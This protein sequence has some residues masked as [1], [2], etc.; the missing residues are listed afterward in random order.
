MAGL[1]VHESQAQQKEVVS[2]SPLTTSSM[3]DDDNSTSTSNS[4]SSTPLAPPAYDPSRVATPEQL[5]VLNLLV[6]PFWIF[7]FVERRMRWANQA[8]LEL[9]NASSL[10]ELQ[11]RDFQDISAASAKRMEEMLLKFEQGQNITEQWTMYP[12]GQAKTVHMNVSGIRLSK[13]DDHMSIM[14]EGIPL[15]KEELLNETLRGV[16]MLRHLPMAVC[17]FDME[18]KVI[19]QNPEGSLF[20]T[21]EE[22][23]DNHNNSE[24][25]KTASAA[26]ND[27]A[28]QMQES[29]HHNHEDIDDSKSTNNNCSN[30]RTAILHNKKRAGNLVNRFVDTDVG[31]HVLKEIQTKELLDIEAMLHTQKGQRWSAIQVRRGKDPVTGE[32]VILYSA[33]D[34][35]DAIKAKKEREARKQKSEFLAIMAHEIRT[36]LHQVTGFIDLLD[37]TNLDAEQRS[38]VKLLK[39]SAQ[40]LMTVISDVLDY[41]KLEAGRMKLE[42]IPYEPLSVVGGSIEAVRASC[43]EKNLYLKV[44]WNKEIP[45]RLL[46]DPNRLRQVL[47]NLLSNAVKFT[48]HGGISVHAIPYKDKHSKEG[49]QPMIKF[50]VKDTGI[51]VG[52]EHKD[53]IF[54]KYQ[55][56]NASVARNFG[57]T[58]LGLSICQ[59]LVQMMNG[60]IGV[61]SEV[62]EG[63]SFWFLVPALVPEE[64]EPAEPFDEEPVKDF[65]GLNILVVEDNKVNQKLLASMLR[66]LGH[67]SSLAENGKEAIEMVAKTDYD[68]VLMDIQMP[69]MDG[70]EATRRLR[71]L[72]YTNLPIFG[73]TA[74]V[75]RSDFTE[76]GFDDWLPKPILMK[77]LK[78]KLY[79]LKKCQV[80]IEAKQ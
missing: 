36:P 34:K 53:L 25:T 69:V 80:L 60:S 67:K 14:C 23:N 28:A 61:D 51:G 55:Q 9:F 50:V 33:Q 71:T 62:G 12:R 5:E 79:R 64:Q 8:G 45:F 52:N 3:G 73:L 2:S 42:S 13:D 10:K 1:V 75:A 6:H 38:F 27:P 20:K 48:D 78:S 29:S 22:Q 63:A 30:S 66:R 4:S 76:L 11:Q 26:E 17:Q 40:G 31:K 59:Q 21:D 47:L 24:E 74:S 70:F 15:V 49:G 58:G 18:G 46:G 37:Q 65:A 32:P 68:T 72:G 43:E 57:G 44:E 56:A 16:E 7:D 41:S 39:S 19:F 77:D 35:S 54:R